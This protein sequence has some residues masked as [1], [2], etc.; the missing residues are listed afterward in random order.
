M[1]NSSSDSQPQEIDKLIMGYL[2]H[3]SDENDL[4]ELID[5]LRSEES[6]RETFSKQAALHG[7][8]TWMHQCGTE[9]HKPNE[10][11]DTATRTPA[12]VSTE[13]NRRADSAAKS[14]LFILATCLAFVIAGGLWLSN[15]KPSDGRNSQQARQSTTPQSA[16]SVAQIIR[17]VDCDWEGDRWSVAKSSDILPGQTLTLSRGLMELQFKSGARVTLE[18]PASFTVESA[19][20]G[21]LDHGKL[22]AEVPE[23]AHGFTINTP[24]GETVDLGTEFG[25]VV[26]KDGAT[27]THVFAGEVVVHPEGSETEELHLEEHMAVRLEDS[28]NP[29]T[30]LAA[31][32]R[33]FVRLDFEEAG[34][35]LVPAI[36]RK[37]S[38]WFSAEH[39]LQRDES[40]RVSAWGDLCTKS[41]ADPQ[42][43][44][45]VEK[46][47]RP[48]WV[49]NAI[50]GLPA[51]RFGRGDLMVT[52]PLKLGNAQTVAVV[53]QLNLELLKKWGIGGDGRQLLNLNGPP[54][55]T[56][57][58]N[59]QLELVSRYHTGVHTKKG[60]DKRYGNVG[61]MASPQPLGKNPVVAVS[62]YDPAANSSKLYI[63]GGLVDQAKAPKLKST[64]SPRY[65]GSHMILPN[66]HF[67]G[68]LAELMIYDAGLVDQEA[69]TLSKQLMKKYGLETTKKDSNLGG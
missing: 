54:H 57:R 51:L 45:Q 50:G 40:G 31:V 46:T 1:S 55:L 62:V 5:L 34:P 3:V 35:A 56:L 20:R 44:W 68:D 48:L 10:Q 67:F 43:A 42:N 4:R 33:R 6:V 24:R 9:S 58:I 61:R 29:T 19:M 47:K 63:N 30:S 39:R 21:I 52:E 38:L 23:S 64:D 13:G 53:F 11:T 66:T 41:N 37:L 16:E 36:D 28:S 32:P 17:K 15:E 7:V 69:L 25:L 65:I 26:A 2:E 59:K 18:A 14:P 60:A 22:T 12:L 49:E 27:E 8:L